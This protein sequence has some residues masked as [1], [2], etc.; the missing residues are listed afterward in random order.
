MMAFWYCVLAVFLAVTLNWRS[1]FVRG[2]GTLV[3]ALSLLMMVSSIV[4]ADV[5]GTFAHRPAPRDAIGDLTPLILNLQA[6]AGTGG[7]LFL[8]WAV[9]RQLC[10]RQVAPLPLLNSKAAFGL[11][12]R[13]AHWTVAILILALIP[14]GMYLSIL[15]LDSPD[16]AGFVTAHQTMGVLVLI[17]VLCRLAW[18]RR[19]PPAAFAAGLKPWEYRLAQSGHVTLYALILAFPLTGLF[20]MMVRGETVRFFGQPIP[21]FVGASPE[22]SSMLTILHDDVL[23]F[24]FYAVFL[25]HLGAVLKHHFVDRR[26]DDV[27]RMIR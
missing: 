26:V 1:R 11:V 16:R 8:L 27:R 12:S 24:A 4:L 3:A 13:Y 17:L 18:L 15:P 9:W 22:W 23:Q 5:N 10:R 2:L 19:S 7:I 6:I 21:A 14:M 25:A 20:M